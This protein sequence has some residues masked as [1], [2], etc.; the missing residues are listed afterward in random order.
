M[1]RGQEQV[2][3]DL[4]MIL[5]DPYAINFL[6]SSAMKILQHLINNES[7][8]RVS[9]LRNIFL[10]SHLLGVIVDKNCFFAILRTTQF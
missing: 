5:C 1:K 8:P 7:L 4:S 3:G 6:A 10:R 9:V 2:L